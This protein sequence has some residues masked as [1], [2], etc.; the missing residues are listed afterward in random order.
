MDLNFLF[1]QQLVSQFL[2]KHASTDEGREKH[3]VLALD[4][5]TRIAEAKRATA[6]G[7]A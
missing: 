1:Q 2:A 6:G 5:G 4:Y 7:A 3:R